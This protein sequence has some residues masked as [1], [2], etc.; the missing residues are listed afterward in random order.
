[1]ATADEFAQRRARADMG[2]FD[3]ILDRDSGEPPRRDDVL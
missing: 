2:A 1:M 3:R